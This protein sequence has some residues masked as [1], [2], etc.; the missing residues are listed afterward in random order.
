VGDGGR[1][2]GGGMEAALRFRIDRKAVPSPANPPAV[3]T[4]SRR[5]GPTAVII[6]SQRD[7]LPWI[8]LR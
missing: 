5:E 8:G 1:G 2:Q 6:R 7:D 3:I 4:G